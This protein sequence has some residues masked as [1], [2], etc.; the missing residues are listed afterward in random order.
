MTYKNHRVTIEVNGEEVELFSQESLNLRINNTVFDPVEILS[1]TSEYSFSFE[2][3]TSPKNCRI[4]GYAN[5]LSVIGKFTREFGTVVYADGIEIF[6]GVLRLSSVTKDSFKCNLVSVKLNKVEDI[7]GDTTMNQLR[8]EVPFT[9]T[10]TLNDVNADM[11]TDYFFPLVCYGAFQKEPDYQQGDYKTYTDLHTIDDTNQWY[12][13]SFHPSFRL[14][15]LVRRCF[16]H[17]GYNVSGDIF[18]DDFAKQIYVSEHLK[19]K[20]DPIYNIGSDKLGNLSMEFYYQNA[21]PPPSSTGQYLPI[22]SNKYVHDNEYPHESAGI[23]RG[24]EYFDYD[25]MYVFDMFSAANGDEYKP[26][27]TINQFDWIKKPDNRYMWRGYDELDRG[28]RIVIPADGMYRIELEVDFDQTPVWNNVETPGDYV[29]TYVNRFNQSNYEWE[30]KTQ[31]WE[32][33]LTN[34]PVEVQLVRNEDDVEWIWGIDKKNQTIYPHESAG[35]K[36][37]I[38]G[39]RWNSSFSG[40]NT[41]FKPDLWKTVA[42]D[43]MV[44]SNFICGLSTRSRSDAWIKNGM[45]WNN[46]TTESNISRFNCNG[47]N[48]VEQ[49]ISGNKVTNTATTKT[50]Y[51]KNTLAGATDNYFTVYNKSHMSG[52]TKG[53]VNLKKNDVLTLKM[54][55][56]AFIIAID[57]TGEDILSNMPARLRVKLNIKPW[58]P[59]VDKWATIS[60]IPNYSN[61]EK[62][63]DTNL[64]LGNFMKADEKMSDFIQDYI[65]SFN[66]NYTQDGKNVFL[67]KNVLNND[68]NVNV[69]DIDHKVNSLSAEA[70]RIEYPASMEV[71]YSIDDSEAGFYSSVPDTHI[72]EDDWKDWADRGSDKIVLADD[73]TASDETVDLKHAYTW[74]QNFKFMGYGPVEAATFVLPVIAKDENFIIQS[75]K[76]MQVDGLGLKQRWWFRMGTGTRPISLKLWNGQMA[77]AAI[78]E[79]ESSEGYKLNYKNEEGSL[80][81]YFFNFM[82]NPDSNFVTV[83]VYLTPQEYI[84]MKNGAMVRFDDDLYY[85]SVISGY[86]PT[87][88]NETELKLIKKV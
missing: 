53:I 16:A 72:N 85:V 65:N 35:I 8:W 46:Q 30:Y 25:K 68:L 23:H 52:K 26:G 18:D 9:G 29:D 88:N 73:E 38:N 50:D 12:W 14:N 32:K 43:P 28:G 79:N 4:F 17:K 45:S 42:Y 36:D 80:L 59:T 34:F 33:N 66:L 49:T 7:F 62:P 82:S 19:D 1:K 71:K 84:D 44:N 75:E 83:N 81:R 60:N 2:L 64:N 27:D 76:A 47:Y 22:W 67:N 69:I 24:D 70:S 6:H 37:G 40:T 77:H 15:E 55:N 86:D 51:N 58:S 57:G 39:G 13:E 11:T 56:W 74:Y 10:D 21:T 5:D 48:K 20:Q 61:P 78:P 3:P 31:Q 63:F 87:G 54:L 41:F